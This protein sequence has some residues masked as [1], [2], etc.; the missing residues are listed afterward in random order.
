MCI[1]D[2]VET[3]FEH[4]RNYARTYDEEKKVYSNTP[5]H[6]QH[7]HPADAFRYLSLTWRQSKMAFPSQ[8]D[9]EK[10]YAG[11]VTNISFG[12]MK[13]EHFRKKRLERSNGY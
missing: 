9:E 5:V 7:S 4:L 13:K 2:S 6:D 3:G 1:R 10:L 8:T 12:A 11:N